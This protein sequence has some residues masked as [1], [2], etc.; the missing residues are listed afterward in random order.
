MGIV[1]KKIAI[2]INT[3]RITVW[4]GADSKSAVQTVCVVILIHD[5]CG[6]HCR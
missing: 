2:Q 1:I 5:I 4:Q 3:F 6:E